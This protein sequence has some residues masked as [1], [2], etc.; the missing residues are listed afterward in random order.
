MGSETGFSGMVYFRT[1]MPQ[2]FRSWLVSLRIEYA[3]EVLSG[4]LGISMNK[5]AQKV[6]FTTKSNFY[7]HFKKITGETPV[8]YRQRITS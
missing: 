2:D 3:K 4:E 7:G 5:L 6:S 8:E 1:Q